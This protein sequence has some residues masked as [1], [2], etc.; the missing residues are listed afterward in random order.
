ML[1]AL[2]YPPKNLFLTQILN[3][4]TPT[5]LHYP[6][7]HLAQF[8]SLESLKIFSAYAKTSLGLKMEKFLQTIGKSGYLVSLYNAFSVPQQTLNVGS[9]TSGSPVAMRWDIE[10]ISTGMLFFWETEDVPKDTQLAISNMVDK[11]LDVGHVYHC[12]WDMVFLF[13][14]EHNPVAGSCKSFDFTFHIMTYH[15]RFTA[16]EEDSRASGVA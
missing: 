10:C 13:Y 12:V 14:V 7:L 9:W 16:I 8:F 15:S 3:R 5:D 2:F 1:N 6:D 11:R 4:S